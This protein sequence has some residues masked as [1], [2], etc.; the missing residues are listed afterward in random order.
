MALRAAH[1]L[2]TQ[3]VEVQAE[4]PLQVAAKRAI[5]DWTVRPLAGHPAA[6]ER[7]VAPVALHATLQPGTK[8]MTPARQ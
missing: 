2:A 6:H 7:T 3:G 8:S 5:L 4:A 1:A